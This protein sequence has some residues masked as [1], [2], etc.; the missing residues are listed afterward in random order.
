MADEETSKANEKRESVTWHFT[1]EAGFGGTLTC[2]FRPYTPLKVFAGYFDKMLGTSPSNPLFELRVINY[3]GE[4][5][6]P[7]EEAEARARELHAAAVKAYTQ[8]AWKL[9]REQVRPKIESALQELFIEVA[10]QTRADMVDEIIVS[11]NGFTISYIDYERSDLIKGAIRFAE[12]ATKKRMKVK[13]GGKKPDYDLSRLSEN[14]KAVYPIWKEAKKIYKQNRNR[15]NWRAMVKVE[16]P[17][18]PDNLIERLAD[19]D[20][21]RAIPSNIALE[22]A[23]QLCG[24]PPDHYT[25]KHLRTLVSKNGEVQT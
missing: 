13:R 15:K 2:G 22:H 18:L 3:A 5:R 24:A 21:Y 12:R 6:L 14:Y 8:H 1:I 25:S 11:P 7:Y 17:D 23:A 19:S 16:Y 9:F 4:N 10:N 20:S